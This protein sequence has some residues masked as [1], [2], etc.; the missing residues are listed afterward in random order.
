MDVIEGRQPSWL[1]ESMKYE[2]G[3]PNRILLN[4]PPNHAKSMTITVDYATWL[5]CQNPNFRILIV[6]SSVENLVS[7]LL[8]VSSTSAS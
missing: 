4:I 2:Q 8:C 5:I 1:H 3:Q 7:K 6:S